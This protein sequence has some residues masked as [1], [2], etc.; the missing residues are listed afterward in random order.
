[1][2]KLPSPRALQPNYNY[3]SPFYSDSDSDYDNLSRPLVQPVSPLSSSSS[4]GKSPTRRSRSQLSRRS[5]NR[6]I[7]Y[8]SSSSPPRYVIKT[9]SP[10]PTTDER[11]PINSTSSSEDETDVPSNVTTPKKAIKTKRQETKENKESQNSPP[12]YSECEI[13]QNAR[14]AKAKKSS[15]A[16]NQQLANPQSAMNSSSPSP[17]RSATNTKVQRQRKDSAQNVTEK[18]RKSKGAKVKHSEQPVP[19]PTITSPLIQPPKPISPLA[20]SSPEYGGTECD[21]KGDAVENDVFSH[22][23]PHSRSLKRQREP[24]DLN[25][26]STTNDLTSPSHKCMMQNGEIDLGQTGTVEDVSSFK[27]ED[28]TLPKREEDFTT[29]LN[30]YPV[31]QNHKDFIPEKEFENPAYVDLLLLIQVNYIRF[32]FL[33]AISSVF[34]S[35]IFILL[36]YRSV[37]QILSLMII[38]TVC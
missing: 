7:S 19:F 32:K 15:F 31:Q 27:R 35:H 8:H 1:M 22:P 30:Y 10:I 4:T 29:D 3:H 24:S 36:I 16:P 13:Q 11:I 23:L 12:S 6:S 26:Q 34:V 14:G 18:G 17:A 37:S 28:A 5:S 21:L 25:S 38:L 9:P 2:L 20:D 33:L